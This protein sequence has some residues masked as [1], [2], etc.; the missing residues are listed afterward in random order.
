MCTA[1]FS[2]DYL[3]M[4]PIASLQA[5]IF[6]L[7]YNGWKEYKNFVYGLDIKRIQKALDQL[8]RDSMDGLRKK[9]LNLYCRAQAH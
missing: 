6:K 3:V 5:V 1:I 2:R 8:E 7:L 9:R 4:L